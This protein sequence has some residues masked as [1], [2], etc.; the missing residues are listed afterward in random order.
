MREEWREGVL[1]LCVCVS[2][3]VCLRVCVCVLCLSPVCVYISL[4]SFFSLVGTARSHVCN[5]LLWQDAVP[6]ALVGSTE[7][8]QVCKSCGSWG[9]PKGKEATQLNATQLNSTQL[10]ATQ[11]NSTQLTPHA[12]NTLPRKNMFAGSKAGGRSI[13]GRQYPWGLVEG[14]WRDDKSAAVLLPTHLHTFCFLSRSLSQ[15]FS[16]SPDLCA[17]SSGQPGPLRLPSPQRDARPVRTHS[18]ALS[19]SLSQPLTHS[20]ALTRTHT[21]SHAL[22]CSSHLQD[23]KDATNEVLYE[24]FRREAVSTD[25]H[26]HMYTHSAQG[27]IMTVVPCDP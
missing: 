21:H 9:G 20:H 17:A 11:L 4:S 13:R 12:A 27:A 25:A 10:N 7:T 19:H 8:F 3:S 5:L 24:T 15:T 1:C 26:T 16:T 14:L 23:L 2:V 22:H 18:H 6:F